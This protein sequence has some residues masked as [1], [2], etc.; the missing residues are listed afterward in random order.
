MYENY[1]NHKTHRPPQKLLNFDLPPGVVIANKYEV[2][3]KLGGGWEGEVY[4]VK[5]RIVKIE[6]T[7]KLFYPKRNVHDRASNFYAKKLHKLRHC[8]IIIQY[9]TQD[10]FYFH[11]VPIRILISE[12]VEGDRLSQFIARQRGKRLSP[13]QALHMLYALVRG[14]ECVHKQGE[15]H[16]DLHTD[17]IIVQRYGLTFDVKVIDMFHWGA[18]RAENIHDDVVDLVKLFYESLGGKKFYKQQPQEIKSIVCGL[19]RSFI[20]KKFRNA[21]KLREYLETMQWE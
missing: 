9:H 20:L 1:I 2:V 5:E 12:Y 14:I 6:R 16:G 18:P 11:G 7:A 3:E 17:N 19:K 13:F 15:Y 21:S 10:T 8:P 4:L